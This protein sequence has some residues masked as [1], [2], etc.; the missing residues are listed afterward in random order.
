MI[1]CYTLECFLPGKPFQSSL[2]FVKKQGPILVV[3]LKEAPL[4]G[5]LLALP[6]LIRLGW[7]GFWGT[8][9]LAYYRRKK[10]YNIGPQ[11]EG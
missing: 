5:G 8:S 2:I 3:N 9:T 4:S 11:I 7:K 6:T 10:F 1:V